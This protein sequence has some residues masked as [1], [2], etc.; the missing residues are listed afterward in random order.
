M[1]DDNAAAEA[2]PEPE[3]N[4]KHSDTNLLY[5]GSVSY[6]PTHTWSIYSFGTVIELLGVDYLVIK[7]WL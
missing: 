3:I 7:F 4:G 2:E 5:Y 1:S 6:I